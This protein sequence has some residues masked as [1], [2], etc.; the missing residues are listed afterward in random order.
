MYTLCM[1]QNRIIVSIHINDFFFFITTTETALSTHAVR[2]TVIFVPL[3][4][5]YSLGRGIMPLIHLF[6]MNGLGY[7]RPALTLD[8]LSCRLLYHI[9]LE[10]EKSWRQHI[11]K[12]FPIEE[13]TDTQL[14][15]HNT[16]SVCLGPKDL[17]GIWVFLWLCVYKIEL[18]SKNGSAGF[19]Y[20]TQIHALLS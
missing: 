12:F 16:I 15:M 13:S 3:K 4:T 8:K 1:E 11:M 17:A 19:P 20:I 2:L 9:K 14:H 18:W 10:P 5:F 7:L 6:K